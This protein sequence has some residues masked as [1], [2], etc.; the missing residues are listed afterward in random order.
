MAQIT[1]P[2]ELC[3]RAKTRAAEAGYAS[4]DASV[5]G[6]VQDELAGEGLSYLFTPERLKLIRDRERSVRSGNVVTWDEVERRIDTL[7][8]EAEWPVSRSGPMPP[9]SLRLSGAGTNSGTAPSGRTVTSSSSGKRSR[10]G[11]PGPLRIG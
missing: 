11:P 4:V 5:E 9:T 3:A 8:C 1:L 2:D 10:I 7:R 6:I